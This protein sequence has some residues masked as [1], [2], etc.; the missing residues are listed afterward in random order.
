MRGRAVRV[1][2]PDGRSDWLHLVAG[3]SGL[4]GGHDPQLAYGR[5]PRPGDHERDAVGDVLGLEHFGALIERVD[6]LT[7][8]AGVVRPEL[9][10]DAARL[11]DANA[12]VVLGDL[13]TQ[14]S[15]KPFTPNLV[16]V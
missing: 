4:V 7:H 14:G 6:A 15:V 5:A 2:E 13:L 12:D 11:E 1:D 16:M 10:G 9:G 3:C 8:R